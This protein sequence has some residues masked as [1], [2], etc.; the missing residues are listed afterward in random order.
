MKY[1]FLSLL[2]ITATAI[3]A[4]PPEKD[5]NPPPPTADSRHHEPGEHDWRA[6]TPE[7]IAQLNK[8]AK[9]LEAAITADPKDAGLNIKLGFTYTRLQKADDAQ[10]AFENAVRLDPKRAIAHY[11]LGLIYEKKGLKDKAIES[12]KAC[13]ANSD[14]DDAHMR[15]TASSH[16]HHLMV[17][18]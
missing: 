4:E 12:W 16:L 11:M 8:E 5:T 13:L 14:S 6:E 7:K 9:T 15:Y 10:R 2:L 18:R 1:L 17:I 3:M